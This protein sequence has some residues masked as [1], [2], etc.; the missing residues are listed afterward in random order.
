MWK[1]QTN[2]RHPKKG[3]L[4]VAFHCV[5]GPPHQDAKKKEGKRKVR[6]TETEIRAVRKLM[7]TGKWTFSGPTKTVVVCE[8][9]KILHPKMAKTKQKRRLLELK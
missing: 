2:A 6:T 3:N 4:T 5:C 7:P 1:F 9:V 8:T